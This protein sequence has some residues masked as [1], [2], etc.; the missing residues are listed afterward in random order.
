MHIMQTAEVCRIYL[1]RVGTRPRGEITIEQGVVQTV[2]S[3]PHARRRLSTIGIWAAIMSQIAL[4][5]MVCWHNWIFLNYDDDIS[6]IKLASH[7]ARGEF[8]LGVSGYWGPL[9]TWL[10]ALLLGL[11]RNPVGAAHIAM[12]ISAV[13]FLL[14]S[15]SIYRSLQIGPVEVILATWITALASIYWS[16][17]FITP[18]L[19]LSGLVCL[20]TSQMLSPKWGE[21]RRA[22]FLA[23]ILFGTAYLAKAVAFPLTLGLSFSIASLSVIVRRMNPKIALRNLGITFAG[24]LLVAVPWVLVL[25][26]KYGHLTISTSAKIAHAIVGPSSHG[27]HPF[28]FYTPE[29]GRFSWWEDPPSIL[30]KDLYWSPFESRR[31]FMH[32]MSII[33]RNVGVIINTLSHF[34]WLSLGLCTAL[35]GFFIHVPW[36]G[37][38]SAQRWRW[39]ALPVACVSLIYLPV[40]ALDQRYYFPVY[41]FLVAS[42]F[43]MVGS[44]THTLNGNMHVSRCIGIAIVTISFLFPHSLLLR[45]ALAGLKNPNSA[46]A[47]DLTHRLQAASIS[48]DIAAAG[49]S[50]HNSLNVEVVSYKTAFFT[51]RRYCGWE[52]ETTPTR[53]KNSGARLVIVDR[54]LPLVTE[55]NADPGFRN[56][57]HILF[58]SNDVADRYPFQVYEID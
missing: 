11:V 27:D 9:L 8:S 38:M 33:R 26:L 39:A 55:L 2:S 4:L 46:Y 50:L 49:S 30:Y 23:G 58:H 22:Q 48:G 34:D 35:F 51:D 29:N 15:V 19:L 32:Q 1:H 6:Y 57:D 17:E 45:Q 28:V 43:G 53:I 47:R 36:R 31:N 20:A 24:F 42:T 12:S 10:I 56:L 41:P 52:R 13:V 5:A 54:S 44:L 40:S 37:N 16:V 14:G 21:S 3:P 18:D 25:S 7:Y